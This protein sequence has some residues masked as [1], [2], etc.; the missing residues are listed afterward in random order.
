M[1]DVKKKH[2]KPHHHYI[3]IL[4]VCFL[5]NQGV[6]VFSLLKCDLNLIFFFFVRN[7]SY[8]IFLLL[9]KILDFCFHWR[10]SSSL[11]GIVHDDYDRTKTHT[12]W[13]KQICW[14][15]YI[16]CQVKVVVF[17]FLSCSFNVEL[18]W[19][20][21]FFERKKK[22]LGFFEK[23]SFLFSESFIIIIEMASGIMTM[24]AGW[25]LH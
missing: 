23:F 16:F 22:N 18:D 12:Q 1:D 25:L 5:L 14:C 21:V 24:M 13:R 15:P 3:I 17:P 9:K 10:S 8:L 7:F 19:K 2:P 6:A 11:S 4:Y 20:K